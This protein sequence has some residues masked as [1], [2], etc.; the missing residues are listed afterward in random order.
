MVA[1]PA[2][3]NSRLRLVVLGAIV[4]GVG[5]RGA[6][7]EGGNY[8][9]RPALKEIVLGGR[10]LAPQLDQAGEIGGERSYQ[11]LSLWPRDLPLEIQVGGEAGAK[12][13]VVRLRSRLEGWQ[14]EWQDHES[15]M[16]LVLRFLDRD[17]RAVSSA[18]FNRVGESPGWGGLPQNSRWHRRVDE[19]VVPERAS[20]VQ[21]LL[22]SGGTPRTTGFWAVRRLRL[23]ALPPGRDSVGGGTEEHGEPQGAEWT[24]AVEKQTY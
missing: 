1:V 9:A 10:S 16:W 7:A 3:I 12:S 14:H 24:L 2:I 17:N 21:V 23:T 11:A 18:A 22:V 20:R 15:Q 5:W 8:S 13:P 6:A 19:A 4:W